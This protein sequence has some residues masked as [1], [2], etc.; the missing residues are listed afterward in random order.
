[1]HCFNNATPVFDTAGRKTGALGLFSD[2]SARRAA[3]QQIRQ[4]SEALALKS[5][6]LSLTLDSLV[7]G[8]LNVDP[9]G[10]CTAWNRRFLE[11]LHFPPEL[12][13]GRP[14]LGDLLDWQRQLATLAEVSGFQ[15]MTVN[16]GDAAVLFNWAPMGTE[17]YVHY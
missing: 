10:R 8:V 6:V 1:M 9:E 13:A 14:R 3:E 5:H 7:Q 4:A 15:Q 17:V 12:M 2:I 11:L 16:L